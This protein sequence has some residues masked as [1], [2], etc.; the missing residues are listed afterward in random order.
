MNIEDLDIREL[1][2]AAPQGGVHL[3]AGQRVL[4]MDAVALGLLR[5]E[6]IDLLGL[7]GARGVMTR[8]GYAHGWRVAESLRDHFPWDDERQWRIAGGRLHTLQGMVRMEAVPPREGDPSPPFAESIWHDSYEAEQH[9]LLV[10]RSE[11][12]VCWSL[13]GFAS[14]YLSYCNQRPI[15][16]VETRCQGKGDPVCHLVGRPKEEWGAALGP[17]AAFY[18]KRCVG[19]ELERLTQSLRDLERKVRRRRRE[20]RRVDPGERDAGGL[21]VRSE[22]M[23]KV[24]EL[25]HRVAKVDSSVLITGESGVGKERLAQ[26]IHERSAREA[27]PMLAIN[28]GAVTDTLLE[29]ELF[30]HARGAFTGATSDRPGLFEAAAGGTLF[31]DEIGEISPA[32]QVKLLRVLQEREVRRVGENRSRKV[33]V[34]VLAATNRNLKEEVAAGRFRQ[35]LFYRLRVIEIEI[36]PLRARKDDILPLARTFLVDASR[37]AGRRLDSFTSEAADLMLRYTWPGNVRELQNAVE[38]AVVMADGGRIAAADLP[39]EVRGG[40]SFHAGFSVGRTLEDVE[41]EVILATLG[42]N[43]G[44]RAQTARDLGIGLATLYRRLQ[45]WGEAEAEA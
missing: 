36:P 37:A 35:D 13:T 2:D 19:G 44:N 25:A 6:L 33:D 18:E 28:C 34:R 45:K 26:L 11:E 4:L 3:F 10:G 7:H 21:V 42:R 24:I 22:A 12:P 9:L 8:F 32:M 5:R 20:L 17:E 15:I 39:E 1:L 29:S 23:R 40:F 30:G 38:R 27:G 16:C 41:R 43:D 14:G 31:L